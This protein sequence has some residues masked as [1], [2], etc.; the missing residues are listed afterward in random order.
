MPQV[1][2]PACLSSVYSLWAVRICANILSAFMYLY[3]RQLDESHSFHLQILISQ[4]A[5]I[6]MAK[7]KSC[8]PHAVKWS[9]GSLSEC[10]STVKRSWFLVKRAGT[11][12][13]EEGETRRQRVRTGQRN[14]FPPLWGQCCGVDERQRGNSGKA[15]VPSYYEA[16]LEL[17]RVLFREKNCKVDQYDS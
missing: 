4:V 16:L 5:S 10:E 13:K 17:K 15:Q 8:Q 14:N 12:M 11:R 6:V 9:A 1:D 2:M 7:N 3:H